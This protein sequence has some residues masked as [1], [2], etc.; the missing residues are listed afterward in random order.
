MDTVS[1]ISCSTYDLDAVTEAVARACTLADFPDVRGKRVLLKPNFL[2][3]DTNDQYAITTHPAVVQAVIRLL[4]VKGAKSIIIGEGQCPRCILP[5]LQ[6]EEID[7]IPFRN[8]ITL[9]NPTGRAL[10]EFS[11]TD[12]ITEI[13]ILISIPKLKTHTYLYYT[14]AIKNMY[15]CIPGK[16]KQTLHKQF[17]DPVRF[18]QMLID[19]SEVLHTD[20][21][22]MDAIIGME[23]QGPYAGI[24]KP[25]GVIL[26]SKNL[27]AMD[28]AAC[29]LAQID[30]LIVSYIKDGLDRAPI[31]LDLVGDKVKPIRYRQARIDPDFP[32]VNIMQCTACGKC[33]QVCPNNAISYMSTLTK[34][35]KAAR[36]DITKCI[37]CYCCQEFCPHKAIGV[38]E[39]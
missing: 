28:Y 22:I 30:P 3:S 6:S 16:Q 4:K 10:Q 23:G 27:L 13:D 36:V 20:F 12:A 11:I 18:G 2:I 7:F 1:Q 33:I 19:L 9:R 8:S 37:R 21:A 29:N 24:P 25:T 17:R 32:K 38:G 31:N 15:G 34:I 14:G 39:E 35:G 5:V 26:A